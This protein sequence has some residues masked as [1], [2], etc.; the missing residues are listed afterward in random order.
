MTNNPAAATLLAHLTHFLP[1]ATMIMCHNPSWR[2]DLNKHIS[3]QIENLITV[4]NFQAIVEIIYKQV[5]VQILMIEINRTFRRAFPRKT[6]NHY[7][8][9]LN[10]KTCY[11]KKSILFN[12]KHVLRKL[13]NFSHLFRG[14]EV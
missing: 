7:P 13:F 1:L 3:S 8:E 10:I 2:A 9:R 4:F 5:R 6:F 12:R 11:T 14:S